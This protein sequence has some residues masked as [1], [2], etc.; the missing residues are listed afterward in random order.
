MARSELGDS[1]P[2]LDHHA[3]AVTRFQPAELS[4]RGIPRTIIPIEQ[5]SPA[6]V[7][8]LG[9][10]AGLPSAPARSPPSVTADCKID[11]LD[12]GCRFR[13]IRQLVRPVLDW[14]EAS[15]CSE[16]YER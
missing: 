1:F 6:R 4:E 10:H 9:C 3:V 7:D 15:A 2:D 14:R 12:Q 11:G 5:S 16:S 8:R 13:E